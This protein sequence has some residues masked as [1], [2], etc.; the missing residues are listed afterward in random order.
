[1]EKNEM[2]GECSTYGERS[3]VYRVLLGK[4]EEKRQLARPRLRWEDN[5]NMNLQEVERGICTGS[6][7]L[8]IGIGGGDL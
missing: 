8:R 5:I 6:F 3:G 7:W 1:M 4:L 2:G